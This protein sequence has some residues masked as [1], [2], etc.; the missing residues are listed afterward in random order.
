MTR[1]YY[2]KKT[3]AEGLL[4]IDMSFLKNNGCLDNPDGGPRSGGLTW[5]N[6]ASGTKNSIGYSIDLANKTI[7][8]F[9]TRTYADE[10][11]KD[12]NYEVNL[13]NSN[14]S[15]GGQRYWFV[16]PLNKNGKP[17]GRRVRVLYQNGDYF[18]CRHCYNLSYASRNVG[19]FQKQYG[20]VLSWPELE[21]M[22]AKIRT[23][24]YRGKPTK[25]FKRYLYL[26]E[27]NDE[28]FIE[29][30]AKLSGRFKGRYGL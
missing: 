23:K 12:F 22:E 19:G 8:L 7:R 1:Y 9:Y 17:C 25:R 20:K 2:D 15:Y 21:E 13:T 14:C 24:Y 11:K 18:G 3:E 4:R 30:V 26:K 29:G 28:S 27:R 5:T 6:S 10:T 16:C